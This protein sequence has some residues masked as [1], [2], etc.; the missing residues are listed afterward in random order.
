MLSEMRKAGDDDRVV[1]KVRDDDVC[2]ELRFIVELETPCGISRK[3]TPEL[4]KNED[5]LG[6]FLPIL[7][8]KH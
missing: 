6:I 5:G 4:K 8:R 7:V 2:N 3:I 1:F